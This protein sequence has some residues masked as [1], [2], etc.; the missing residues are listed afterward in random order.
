MKVRNLTEI[1]A[2]LALAACISHDGSYSPDCIAYEGS[3][4]ELSDGRFVWERFT[5]VV[6]VD[7]DGQVI[8]RFP[9]FPMEGS[10]R[11]DGH[12]VRMESA[13]G[14]SLAN[15][16]LHR[17]DGRQYLLTAE[18]A[19]AWENTG[20]QANCPLVLGGNSRD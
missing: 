4:I 12:T 10:Y 1:F 11:I 20:Q 6:M 3:N 5:D 17:I 2:V 15:M 7:A 18:Q 19:E 8:N 13:S 9:G 14:E 16:Y